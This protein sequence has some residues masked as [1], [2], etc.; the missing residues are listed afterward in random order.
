A[1]GR[2]QPPELERPEPAR[3]RPE[4]AANVATDRAVVLDVFADAPG[5]DH[6]NL[7][8]EYA[9]LTNRAGALLDISHW[10]LCDAARHCFRFPPGATIGPR[11]RVVVFTG[12]GISDGMRFYMGS[13]A[14]VWNNRGD[15]ATLTDAGGRVVATFGY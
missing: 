6:K 5:N 4:D 2:R 3:D 9:V 14:A 10:V 8:G 11:G 13:G 1:R 12:Q 15:T 7:N